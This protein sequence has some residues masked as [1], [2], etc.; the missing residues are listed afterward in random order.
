L[1]EWVVGCQSLGMWHLMHPLAGS[2]GHV[3]LACVD[4]FG[5]IGFIPEGDLA[6]GVRALISGTGSAR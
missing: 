3:V 1:K 5:V 4:V 6:S 2:T